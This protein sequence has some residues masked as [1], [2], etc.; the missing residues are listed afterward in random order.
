[1]DSHPVIGDKQAAV[2][3]GDDE[4][5]DDAEVDPGPG[6]D[7]KQAAVWLEQRGR[8]REASTIRRHGLRLA[9]RLRRPRPAPI[10]HVPQRRENTARPRERRAAPRRRAR[11]PTGDDPSEPPPEPPPVEVWRGL[12]AASVRMVQHCERRRA[13]WAAA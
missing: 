8:H 1:V 9:I 3:L 13:K 12:A 5:L 6:F 11:A 2:W 7:H 4:E 10:N